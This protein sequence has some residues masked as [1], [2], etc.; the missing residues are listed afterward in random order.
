MGRGP[1]EPKQVWWAVVLVVALLVLVPVLLRRV[2][3]W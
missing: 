1:A 3:V 2:L